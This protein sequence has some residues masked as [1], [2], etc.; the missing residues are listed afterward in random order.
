MKMNELYFKQFILANTINH[1]NMILNHIDHHLVDEEK[2]QIMVIKDYFEIIHDEI[3][4]Q[5]KKA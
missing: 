3:I 2:V 1:L 4:E 5:I